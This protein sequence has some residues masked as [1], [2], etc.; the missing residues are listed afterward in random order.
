MLTAN[1]EVAPTREAQVFVHDV[2]QFVTVQLLEETL[3]PIA[4]QALQRPRILLWVGQ[5][6]RATIDQKTE[7]YFFCKTDNFVP[8]VVPGLSGNSE[9]SSSSATLPHRVVGTRCTLSLWKAEPLADLPK[10]LRMSKKNLKDRWIA[11]TRTQFSGIR[12]RTSHESGDKI[13]EAQYLYSL[14]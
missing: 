2:N 4:R 5:R 8:L 14:P 13:K 6:S 11:C 3:G 7:K 1:C 12:S 9:S 10:G